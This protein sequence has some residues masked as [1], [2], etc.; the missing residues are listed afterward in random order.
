MIKLNQIPDGIVIEEQVV[1]FVSK[2]FKALN[3]GGH[4]VYPNSSSVWNK[5]GNTISLVSGDV[6]TDAN[7][8]FAC[9]LFMAGY[10]VKSQD[11]ELNN[12]PNI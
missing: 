5:N 12:K 2:L 11:L 3:N 4:Y 10:N 1:Q 7:L 9:H 6:K 8:T